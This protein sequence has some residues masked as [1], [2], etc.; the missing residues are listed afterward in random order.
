MAASAKARGAARVPGVPGAP[1][2]AGMTKDAEA[3]VLEAD[4]GSSL[5]FS[6]AIICDDLG[7]AKDL[8]K[9]IDD[10]LKQM[11]DAAKALLGKAGEEFVEDLK[12]SRSGSSVSLSGVVDTKLIEKFGEMPKR[13]LPF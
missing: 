10:G 13:G 8:K 9:E 7:D 1:S 11:E 4:F 5:K 3:I 6:V 12:V 2:V